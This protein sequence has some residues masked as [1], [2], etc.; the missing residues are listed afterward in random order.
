MNLSRWPAVVIL[1][2]LVTAAWVVDRDHDRVEE[3]GLEVETPLEALGYLPVAAPD[4]AISST[5]YCGGG[6]ADAD[7]SADVTIVVANATDRDLSGTMT[8]FSNIAPQLVAETDENGQPIEPADDTTGE[9]DDG[10]DDGATTT[11]TT[12]AP[13]QEPQLPVTIDLEVG[14]ADRTEVRLGDEVSSDFAAALVELPGGAVAVE[15]RVE[16]EHGADVAPCTS[17]PSATWYFADGRTTA[18]AVEHLAFFNPFPDAATVDVTI[19]TESDLRTPVQF[20]GYTVP[21]QTLVVEDIGDV[22]PRHEHVSVAVVARSGRLVVNRLLELDGEEDVDGNVGPRGLDVSAGAALPA[23][24]W[25]FP[26]GIVTEGVGETYVVYNPNETA[27]EVDL[28]VEPDDEAFGAIEPFTLSIPPGGFQEVALPEEERIGTAI[29]NADDVEPVL[30]HSARVVSV[31]GIPVVAERVTDGGPGSA[32]P[33]FDMTFG[34]P[35]LMEEAVIA[36]SSDDQ[37]VIVANPSGSTPVRVTFRSLD[38]GTLGESAA[39]TDLE[40][41]VAGRLVVSLDDLGFGPDVALLVTADG[42]VTI[43]RRLALGEPL[44]TSAAIAVPLAGTVSE[45]EPQFG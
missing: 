18:D 6:T 9:D 28:F 10:E 15:Q 4:D 5:W 34:S 32:R 14:A 17:T 2:G 27:A 20:T 30:R 21:G 26:D 3:A 1:A 8:I 29:S 40:V 16:G 24:T 44:D 22:V 45:P 36:S 43:E 38:G 7:G 31:N 33:G 12:T 13:A 23:L 35:L 25:F 41:P 11:T 39:A 42:P 37:S 19:R